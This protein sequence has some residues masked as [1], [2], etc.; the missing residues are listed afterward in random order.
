MELLQSD[1]DRMLR[2]ELSLQEAL[3]NG[4]LQPGEENR[5]GRGSDPGRKYSV[6]SENKF[7]PRFV[8]STIAFCAS[9]RGEL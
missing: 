4:Q 3:L 2:A 1:E 8:P 7:P 5:K 6:R 9:V